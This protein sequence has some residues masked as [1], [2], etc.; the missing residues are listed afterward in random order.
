MTQGN[1]GDHSTNWYFSL[2]GQQYGPVPLLE[3]RQRI[4]GAQLQPGDLV[5]HPSLPNWV[6]PS[7]LPQFADIQVPLQYQNA[8]LNQ[9]GGYAGFWL[10]VGA[11]IIDALVL[12]IPGVLIQLP[13]QFMLQSQMRG[14]R[15]GQFPPASFFGMLAGIY[16]IDICMRWLYFALMESSGK[17]GTLGKMACGIKVTDM[18][19]NRIGFGQATGRYF[20][21][22]VSGLTIGIGFI[23]AGTTEKK[24]GLHDIMAKTL[25]VRK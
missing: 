16:A 12:W 22:I 9:G 1:T 13:F 4:A 21:K 7:T 11:S 20:G 6:M 15:P 10:R 3:L 14:V 18:D 5:W 2:Q 17:Q 19:G 24:Q 23:M 25:V 8:Y